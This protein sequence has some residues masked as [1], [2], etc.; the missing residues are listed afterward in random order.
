MHGILFFRLE[1]SSF[2]ADKYW[3]SLKTEDNK[4]KE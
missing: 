1:K 4:E 3:F 2:P